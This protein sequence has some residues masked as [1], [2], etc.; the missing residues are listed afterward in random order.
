M[1]G[2]V[3]SCWLA[4]RNVFFDCVIF[5]IW[6]CTFLFFGLLILLMLRVLLFVGCVYCCCFA[7]I[8]LLVGRVILLVSHVY[9][10]WLAVFNVVG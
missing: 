9:F 1:V 5:I 4:V 7:C 6:L 2:R 10:C 3:Y 8:L